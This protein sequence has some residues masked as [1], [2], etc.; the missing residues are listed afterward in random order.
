[1]KILKNSVWILLSSVLLVHAC[2][3][4]QNQIE[5]TAF[6]PIQLKEGYGPFHPGFSFVR[7]STKDSPVWCKT[8]L[9]VN[10]IPKSWSRTSVSYV[11]LNNNQFVYQNFIVGNINLTDYQGLQK[12]WHLFPDTNRVSKKP[13]RCYIYVIRGFDEKSGKWVV[14]VDTNNNLDFS[15]EATIHPKTID[16][17]DP[18]QYD[19]PLRIQ[20]EIYQKGVVQPA[21]LPMV[22]KMYGSELLYNFPQYAT[23][24]LKKGNKEYQLTLASG[25]TT[26]DFEKTRLVDPSSLFFSGKIEDK[27]LIEIDDVV[28]IGG[29][30]YRNKGVDVFNN[31]LELEPADGKKQPYSLQVG[32]S[33]QPFAGRDFLTG[34][35]VDLGNYR[36]KYVYI[37]FW[38]TGCKGCVQDMPALVNIYR[39]VDTDKVAFIGITLDSPKRL[40][41][42]MVKSPLRWPQVISNDTN[43]LFERYH[44]TGLPTSV[45]ISP[46]GTIIARNI[47]PDELRDALSSQLIN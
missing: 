9:S 35:T 7:N 17:K 30:K 42:F 11:I 6:L 13:I 31:W 5:T 28:A 36:G 10:G 4:P 38:G 46:N 8:Y 19:K 47:R 41:T 37:D 18:Y 20:Y 34:R 14:K 45:L 2:T 15:D 3:Q 16:P 21:E 39:K 25:F 26:P 27:D 43:Q 32:N 40:K 33:F 1:M 29:S 22:V 44:V 24:T 12:D 23:T